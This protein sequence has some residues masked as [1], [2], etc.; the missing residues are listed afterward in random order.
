MAFTSDSLAL[1]EDLLALDSAI[2]G[3]ETYFPAKK[4]IGGQ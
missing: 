3:A 2:W 4:R 1:I